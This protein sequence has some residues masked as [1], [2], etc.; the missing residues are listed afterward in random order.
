MQ[1]DIVANDKATGTMQK[2]EKAMGTF[3]QNMVGRFT[4]MAA[5]AA[6]VVAAFTKVMQVIKETGDI[7]DESAKLGLSPEAYQRLK[8]AAEDYGAS[9]ENVATALKD[10]NKLLDNAASKGGPDKDV[11]LALGFSQQEIADRAIKAE[12]VFMRVADAIKE[13]RSEEEK[14]A[15]ASRIVGDRVAQ[16]MVPILADYENFI[17]TSKEIGVVSDENARVADAMATRFDKRMASI[18][19]TITNFV[20]NLGRSISPELDAPAEASP[21]TQA[22]IEDAKRRR[23][24][25]LA[26]ASK[27]AAPRE[28]QMAV[29]SLQQIGGGVARGPSALEDYAA[30]TAVATE[31]IAATATEPAPA[32]T[33]ATDV[34]KEPAGRPFI[35]QPK[36]TTRK[37]YRLGPI[38]FNVSNK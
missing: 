7:A 5:K 21:R 19:A 11:L 27:S 25:L 15:I 17:R 4:M 33:G 31:T 35:D 23:D 18:K 1:F 20:A 14:F 2:T 34:T 29:T 24:A 37:Q 3:T 13:A 32:P 28:S 8:F 22:Q 16:A 38:V 26:A 10:V 36:T 9:I 6:L 12:E 30:R